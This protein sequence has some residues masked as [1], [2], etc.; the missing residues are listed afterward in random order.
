VEAGKNTSTVIHASPKR[1]RKGNSVVSYETVMYG[2]ES[3]ATLT[4]DTLHYTLQKSPLVREGRILPPE[5]LRVVR[6]DGNGNP[7][8]S[9][10]TLMYGYES[11]AT[12]TTDTLHYTLQKGPLVRE[13][14]ILPPESLRVIR[15]DGKGTQWSQMRQ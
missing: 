1:R 6:G 15:G 11:S 10:E 4:T 9:D 14:R 3:S 12:L 5:S 7:V 8:V 2:Y 13:G